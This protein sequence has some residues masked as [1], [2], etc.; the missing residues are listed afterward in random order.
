MFGELR[1]MD[2]KPAT[3]PGGRRASRVRRACPAGGGEA[4]PLPTAPGDGGG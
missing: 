3:T 4:G 1:R 2:G